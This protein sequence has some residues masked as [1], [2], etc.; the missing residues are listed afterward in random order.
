MIPKSNKIP[1][2]LGIQL[3]LWN[4]NIPQAA[5]INDN[6]KTKIIINAILTDL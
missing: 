1:N 5:P 2:K 4:I 6:G 3:G